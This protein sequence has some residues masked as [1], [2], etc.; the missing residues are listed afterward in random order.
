M[1]VSWW[2]II[3]VDLHI[4]AVWRLM[5]TFVDIL[6]LQFVDAHKN[7]KVIWVIIIYIKNYNVLLN[8]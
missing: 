6:D 7:I 4:I 5:Q 3:K 1:L 8:S 2:K